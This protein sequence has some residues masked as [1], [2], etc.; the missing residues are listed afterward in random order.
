MWDNPFQ[1]M[2]VDM[3]LQITADALGNNDGRN[4]MLEEFRRG[5]DP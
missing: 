2:G 1:V 5:P 3:V 4:A